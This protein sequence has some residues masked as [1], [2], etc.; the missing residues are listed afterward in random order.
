MQWLCRGLQST[1]FIEQTIRE[2]LNNTFVDA[3]VKFLATA[4]EGE[5]A[6]PFDGAAMIGLKRGQRTARER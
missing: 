4:F 3:T 1:D 6:N 2:H 5:Y